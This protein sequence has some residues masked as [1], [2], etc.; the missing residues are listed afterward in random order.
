VFG[1]VRGVTH[2]AAVLLTTTAALSGHL[3]ASRFG[4]LIARTLLRPSKIG[5]SSR[6]ASLPQ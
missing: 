3:C 2:Q 1:E 5:L 4:R 6:W